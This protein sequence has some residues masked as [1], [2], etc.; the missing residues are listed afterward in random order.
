MSRR[1][2]ILME[3]TVTGSTNGVTR[4]IEVI[5]EHLSR[6]AAYNIVWLRFIH[7]QKEE[8][9]TKDLG[10][11][12]LTSIALP[13]ALGDFL[14][15]PS[16][17]ISYWE[18]TYGLLRTELGTN[19]ILH[20]HTLNLI[21]LALLIKQHQTCKIVTHLHCIP[22]KSLYNK[23]RIYFNQLYAKHVACHG[24]SKKSLCISH[25]ESD[26][27]T[28]SDYVICVTECGRS[29]VECSCPDHTK[30]L[31]V[32][33][34][35]LMDIAGNQLAVR[36]KLHKP[37]KLLFVG[38]PN[39]SKGLMDI[40]NVL[41]IVRF[42]AEVML[43]VI[44]SFTSFQQTNIYHQHPFL[45]IRFV[46]HIPLYQLREYYAGHDI[47]LIASLQEQCSY[48]AIE[49]M[50]FGLPVVT[51]DVDGLDEIFT[52]S[53]AFK[54]PVVFSE[55]YGLRMD[56]MKMA[57]AIIRLINDPDLRI[58]IS[59]NARRHYVSK[60]KSLKMTHS[61]EQIYRTL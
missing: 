61:I 22:W 26:C 5:I 36:G 28:K 20:L 6:S 27:Y 32:I 52:N 50:M 54:I 47:G 56:E 46:G 25:H 30:K 2:I 48:V 33:P 23:D 57:D 29:H 17:R 18:K 13:R 19:P 59:K 49:M 43:T 60:Y 58:R 7:R 53:C 16:E 21:E 9:V 4:C 39:P 35:G 10:N 51:T 40:L 14:A 3:M 45:D 34:N 55:Q 15:N 11:Y 31:V 44:G 1:N 42:K 41:E 12:R 8:W 37:V 24:A 38:N